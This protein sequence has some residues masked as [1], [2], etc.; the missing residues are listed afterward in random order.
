MKISEIIGYKGGSV[1]A[2]DAIGPV[3]LAT[4]YIAIS[5]WAFQLCARF[6]SPAILQEP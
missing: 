5:H 4:P 6:P 2:I 1:L 3:L